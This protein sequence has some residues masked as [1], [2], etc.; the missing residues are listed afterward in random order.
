M[1]L[2]LQSELGV[3]F[4]GRFRRAI[5]SNS[6]SL[7]AS[8]EDYDETLVTLLGDVATYYTQMRTLEKRIDYTKQNVA[9][10]QRT[11]TIAEARFRGGTS[12][13]RDPYQAR[14]TLEQTQAQIPE[15]EIQRRQAVIQLCILLGMPPEELQTKLG[16]APIPVAPAEVAVGIP[17]DLLAPS[18]R[19]APSGAASGRPKRAD[20]HRRSRF[21]SGHLHQRDVGLFGPDFGN[22]FRADA[23]NSTVGPSFQWNL[24]NYGRILNNVRFQDARFQE[25]VAA[26]QQTVLS[27]AQEVENGLVTFLR[28]RE[29]TNFQDACAKDAEKAVQIVQA[30]YDGG[31]VDLTPVTLLQQ[32]LVQQQDVLVQAQGEIA[33]GLISVYRALRRRLADP[34]HRLRAEAIDDG[35]QGSGSDSGSEP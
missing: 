3:D 1:E 30:Q 31:T 11:V 2:R 29:R 26:Y 20:R 10:Q 5:E 19:G 27:A 15:L 17:A 4:W 21:L 9:L 28:A 24:L 25:L 34:L 12:T 7:E 13:E 22:L 32:T 35:N 16:P 33:L 8:V 18:A 23:L 6:A 14:S